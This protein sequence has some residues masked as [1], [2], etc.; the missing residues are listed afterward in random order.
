MRRLLIFVL[1]MAKSFADDKSLQFKKESN[2]MDN[3]INSE[4]TKQHFW[5][6]SNF[7]PACQGKKCTCKPGYKVH[8]SGKLCEPICRGGCENGYCHYPGICECYDGYVK[9]SPISN[10]CV[11]NCSQGCRGGNCV[12]PEVCVCKPG[13]VRSPLTLECLP[14]CEQRCVN[15]FCYEPN[16]CRCNPGYK[17]AEE[18]EQCVPKCTGGCK[19]GVCTLP[20]NCLCKQ[21]YKKVSANICMPNCSPP[22]ENGTCIAPNKCV[23]RKSYFKDPRIITKNV[24]INNWNIRIF[25]ND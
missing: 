9:E 16:R 13:Y 3:S 14:L 11:A 15:G 17:K 7:W 1:V 10:A 19:N 12:A 20:E 22:C 24:C 25:R 8:E 18:S 2:D 5:P 6:V 4:R 21:G 23:C